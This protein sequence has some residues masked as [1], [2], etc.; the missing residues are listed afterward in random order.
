M[1][2]C[3]RDMNVALRNRNSEIGGY[4][5]WSGGDKYAAVSE[6]AVIRGVRY[7]RDDGCNVRLDG[8]RQ[9]IP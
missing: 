7:G 8:Q 2:R 3:C 6:K 9:P 1:W 5:Y 4:V